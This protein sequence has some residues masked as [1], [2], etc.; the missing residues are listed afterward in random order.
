MVRV[1]LSNDVDDKVDFSATPFLNFHLLTNNDDILWH[2]F[3]SEELDEIVILFDKNTF[4]S[5]VIDKNVDGEVII[6]CGIN[7]P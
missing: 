1:E 7:F 4:L 2:M 6:P 3:C 5:F